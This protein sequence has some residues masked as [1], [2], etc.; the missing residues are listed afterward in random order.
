[1]ELLGQVYDQYGYAIV[2]LG[3]L[4]KHPEV[5]SLALQGCTLAPL[6]RRDRRLE[7]EPVGH[8]PPTG[9]PATAGP[10]SPH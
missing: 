3:V 8:T 10:S 5:L 6:G 2:F 7:H 4:A 1:M 9:R